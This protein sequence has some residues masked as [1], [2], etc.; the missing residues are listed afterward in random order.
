MDLFRLRNLLFTWIVLPGLVY[1]PAFA[2]A[3]PQG[4]GWLSVRSDT[5]G[6]TVRV[7]GAVIGHTPLDSIPFAPGTVAVQVAHP[8]PLSW[9]A[10][11]VQDTVSIHAGEVTVLDARFPHPVWVSADPPH[12]R[13]FI[14]GRFDGLTPR[15][16]FCSD[17]GLTLRFE[18]TGYSS[19]SV[20]LKYGRTPAFHVTLTPLPEF[21]VQVQKAPEFRS[22]KIWAAGLVSLASGIAG[23]VFKHLAEQS[24]DRY[25][26]AGDPDTMDRHYDRAVLYDR[27]A[28]GCYIAC[29]VHFGLAVFFSIREARRL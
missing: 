29:E 7:D 6:L 17:T 9:T 19:R 21:N 16:V 5:A 8:D 1:A 12:S 3:S 23:Y 24:Y 22:G 26:D 2:Q 14:R 20:F 15:Y 25:M 11:D 13:L 27:I 10:R 4:T 28:G 18:K